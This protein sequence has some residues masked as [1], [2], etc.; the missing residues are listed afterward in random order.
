MK[1][2]KLVDSAFVELGDEDV[3]L[4]K[5]VLKS[6]IREIE[7]TEK[8]LVRLRGQYQALLKKSIEEVVDEA[9]NGNI[10]F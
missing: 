7:K 3:A 10:R 6:R 5:E 2:R 9:E 8:V 4:A 1:L